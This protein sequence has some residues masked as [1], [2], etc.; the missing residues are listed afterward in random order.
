MADFVEIGGLK[1]NEELYHLVRDEIVP[2]T[3]VNADRFWKSFGEIVRD[4]APK[5]RA[6]LEKRHKLQKQ[7]DQYHLA[8]KGQPFNREEYK[9]FLKEIGY[10]VPEGK[11]FKVTTANVDPEITKIAGAQLVVPLDNARYALNAANARWGS[12][13]DALYGTNVITEEA[14]AE[15]GEF[16]NPRRG[17]KVIAY[18]EDFLDKVVSLKRGSFSDVT[19]F[20]LRRGA[21]KKQLAATLKD[22]STVG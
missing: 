20:F 8:R 16:Y 17:A 21:G 11:R 3:G 18:T 19:R 5:N 15:K 1:V 6:L 13:Y 14:G 7:I 12:L 4:L 2:G 10:L 22:G 9:T